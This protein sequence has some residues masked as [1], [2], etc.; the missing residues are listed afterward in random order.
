TPAPGAT[1]RIAGRRRGQ[2][3]RHAA[4]PRRRDP[5]ARGHTQAETGRGLNR[6]PPGSRRF[7]ADVDNGAMELLINIDVPDLAAA[8]AFYTAA[9]ELRPARRFGEDAV[10][11]LGAN[12][13]IYLLH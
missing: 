12:A 11:L 13:P 5:R 8:E 3:H 2:R 7:G 9:F 4:R 10:E 6:C 1:A